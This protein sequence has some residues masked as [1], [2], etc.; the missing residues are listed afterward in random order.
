LRHLAVQHLSEN[1]ATEEICAYAIISNHFHVVLHVD[2]AKTK[3]GSEREVNLQ[4]TQ[5]YKGQLLADRY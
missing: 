3:D 1:N 5:L 2:V 4:W